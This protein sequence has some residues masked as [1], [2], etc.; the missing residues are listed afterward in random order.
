MHALLIN[1]S[2]RA[3]SATAALAAVVE[4]ALRAR[5]ATVS[6]VDLATDAGR[7]PDARPAMLLGDSA[8]RFDAVVLASPVHHASYSGLLKLTL[9]GLPGDWLADTAVGLLAHGGGPRSGSVVC[10][11]L[12]TVA[13]SL[14]GWVVPTQVA[15]CPDDFVRLA[16]GTAAPDEPLLRRCH[17]LATELHRCATMLRHSAPTAAVLP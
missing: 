10:E 6:T 4:G 11:H 17:V 8:P 3:R 2:P 14:G 5:G 7:S 16:D 13:K 15:A 12:R 9:D 1:G